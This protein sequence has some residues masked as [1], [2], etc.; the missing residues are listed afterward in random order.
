MNINECSVFLVDEDYGVKFY[1]PTTNLAWDLF[2]P[3]MNVT[4]SDIASWQN[5]IWVYN[6]TIIE[7]Y[8]ITFSPFTSILNRTI[9]TG[10]QN[11]GKG[12]RAL[13]PGGGLDFYQQRGMLNK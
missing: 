10:G 2:N 6:N 7:E 1:D 9:S 4:D 3:S 13:V 11:L 8:Y 5:Y 12:L